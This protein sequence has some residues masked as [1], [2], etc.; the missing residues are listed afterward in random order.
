MNCGRTPASSTSILAGIMNVPL[1]E[2]A[3]VRAGYGQAAVLRQFQLQVPEGGLISVLGRNGVGK[4]TLLR[5]IIGAIRA[6]GGE[7]RLRG[8]AIGHLPMHER[9]RAGIAYVPQGREIF[10]SLSVLDNLKAAA[11]GIGRSDWAEAVEALLQ[12]FR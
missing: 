7:I 11:F 10:P 8:A 2:L 9:A 6:Q 5:T 4:T 1:L 12:E 3:D